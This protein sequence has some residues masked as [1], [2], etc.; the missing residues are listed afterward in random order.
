M[1][2]D[3][4]EPAA[5]TEAELAEHWKAALERELAGAKAAGDAETVKAV[6]AQLGRSRKN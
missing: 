3:V 1:S 2:G 4:H 6:E 5:W